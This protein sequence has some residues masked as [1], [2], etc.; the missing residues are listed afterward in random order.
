MENV[1]AISEKIEMKACLESLRDIHRQ[2]VDNTD[3]HE[4]T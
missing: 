4:I 2:H 3:K 1:V